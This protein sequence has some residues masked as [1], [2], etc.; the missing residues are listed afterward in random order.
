MPCADRSSRSPLASKEE[1]SR[2][3]SLL[4]ISAQGSNNSN[5]LVCK[6]K[7][8]GPCDGSEEEPGQE[9]S[10]T[11]GGDGQGPLPGGLHGVSPG[12]LHADESL[13]TVVVLPNSIA[14][15]LTAHAEERT[16]PTTEYL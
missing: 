6:A 1:Y 3:R 5:I 11:A 13:A 7:G 2:A 14:G 16:P 10:H 9:T 4:S 12:C 8:L 15:T